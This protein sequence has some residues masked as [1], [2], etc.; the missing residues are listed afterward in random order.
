PIDDADPDPHEAEDDAGQRHPA[1]L[2]CAAGLL[3]LVPG[4]EA[5]D[6]R[7]DGGDPGAGDDP[8]EPATRSRTRSSWTWREPRRRRKVPPVAAAGA[9]GPVRGPAPAVVSRSSSCPPR[10]NML[11]AARSV[12]TGTR[13]VYDRRRRRTERGSPASVP[14]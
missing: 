5:E 13:A 12:S 1:S 2:L 11:Q 9:A 8:R 4:D 3:D 10:P 14:P 6:D 7:E